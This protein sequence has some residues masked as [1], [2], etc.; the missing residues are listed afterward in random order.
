M[1]KKKHKKILVLLFWTVL[2]AICIINREKMSVETIRSVSDDRPL[3]AALILW[4]FF[5]VK[6]VSVV[7][8]SGALFAAS[9]ILFLL[10][11]AIPVSI[12]GAVIMTSI[13]FFFGR[14]MAK[15]ELD[16]L[17]QKNEKLRM[18]AELQGDNH[19]LV[20]F[21]VRIISCLPSDLVSMYLGASGFRYLQYIPGTILGMLPDIVL[22][23]II[24]TSIQDPTSSGF[25]ISVGVKLLFSVLSLLIFRLWRKQNSKTVIH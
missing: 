24:G 15:D 11:V 8:Y 23:T 4:S 13:P 3:F 19:F 5:A 20:A 17:L 10:P 16:A 25:L 12:L 7:L 9:G 1:N 21:F 6:S 2:I 18:V 14:G 22:I